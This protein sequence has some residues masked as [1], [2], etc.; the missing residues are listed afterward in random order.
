MLVVYHVPITPLVLLYPVFL[1][2]QLVFIVGLALALSAAAARLRDTRHLLDVGLQVL[3]YLTPIIYLFE[4]HVPQRFRPLVLL[5]PMSSFVVA[6]QR[7]L[8]YGRWP[9]LEAT[10]VATVYAA[11]ALGLGAAFFLRTDRRF[12]E[13]V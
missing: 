13:L 4:V 11:A 5:S 9:G 10:V 7:I 8:Y 3:F 1:F 12:T 6:Y 2:L